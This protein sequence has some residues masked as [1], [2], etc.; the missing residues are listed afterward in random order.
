MF[1]ITPQYHNH[2]IASKF[3]Y[4]FAFFGTRC[5]IGQEKKIAKHKISDL[6]MAICELLM[7]GRMMVLQDEITA[8][9]VKV[10]D[11][12]SYVV[13]S[14]EILYLLFIFLSLLY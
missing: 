9:G 10:I 6:D 8:V 13:Y 3:L 4:V 5:V 12:W 14:D 2:Y 11:K 7:R 1:Q